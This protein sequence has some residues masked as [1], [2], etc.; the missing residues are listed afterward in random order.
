HDDEVGIKFIACFRGSLISLHSMVAGNDDNTATAGAALRF[1]LLVINAN[2]G[3]S[4]LDTFLNQTAYRKGTS[5]TGV[6]VE[7]HRKVHRFRNKFRSPKRFGSCDNS[8]V[9]ER[10]VSA[11][12]DA[13]ADKSG[14]NSRFIHRL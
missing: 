9:T 5:V 1:N 2:A 11:H 7:N 4:D 14:F 12:H 3:Q 8:L 13:C 6:T 10:G